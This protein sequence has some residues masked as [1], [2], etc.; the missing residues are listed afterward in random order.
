[1]ATRLLDVIGAPALV[2]FRKAR[3]PGTIRLKPGSRSDLAVC[4]IAPIAAVPSNCTHVLV[5]ILYGLERETYAVN[6]RERSRPSREVP[7]MFDART[8]LSAAKTP[9]PRYLQTHQAEV[10]RVPVRSNC[11]FFTGYR[12][13]RSTVDL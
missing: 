13:L 2:T 7:E 4:R 1:M 9:W 10:W 11:A 3:F 5:R 6:Y 12:S 8:R